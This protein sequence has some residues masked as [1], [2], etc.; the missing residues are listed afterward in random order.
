MINTRQEENWCSW[1]FT[2]F[3]TSNETCCQIFWKVSCVPKIWQ[4]LRKC[5]LLSS[6]MSMKNWLVSV[7]WPFK[8]CAFIYKIYK[9]NLYWIYIDIFIPSM[10]VENW[11][12]ARA[13]E[14]KY[15][16]SKIFIHADC[17]VDL[18][19]MK[20]FATDTNVIVCFVDIILICSV[21]MD[22]EK[23][24]PWIMQKNKNVQLSWKHWGFFCK[25]S[26][27]AYITAR[28]CLTVITIYFDNRHIY[29]AEL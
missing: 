28:V 7:C 10:L 8:I 5:S 13:R 26:I 3:T 29:A 9:K 15:I 25:Y 12:D 24:Q 4:K 22:N 18:I 21:N 11:Y 23:K 6:I 17:W 16:Q 1:L 20:I 19:M 2:T 27:L 14:R